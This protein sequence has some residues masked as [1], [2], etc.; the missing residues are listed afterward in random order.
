[1]TARCLIAAA[2]SAPLGLALLGP[3]TG[4]AQCV[5]PVVD[6]TAFVASD[7]TVG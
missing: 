6:P 3:G 7:A 1:M 4:G 5:P 2:L